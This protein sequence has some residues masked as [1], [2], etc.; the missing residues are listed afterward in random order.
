MFL[1]TCSDRQLREAL[2]SSAVVDRLAGQELVSLFHVI[3]HSL[4]PVAPQATF[5]STDW[6]NFSDLR[7]ARD[8]N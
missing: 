8:G 6:Y 2:T 7:S 5:T 1:V 4:G 3:I